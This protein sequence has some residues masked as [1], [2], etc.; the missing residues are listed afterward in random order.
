MPEAGWVEAPEVV[1]VK[2]IV[3]QIVM[4]FIPDS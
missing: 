1:L 3:D 4:P 2:N